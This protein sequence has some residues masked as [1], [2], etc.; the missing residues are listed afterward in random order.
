MEE[1]PTSFFFKTGNKLHIKVLIA[2]KCKSPCLLQPD[3]VFSESVG[4]PAMY[5]AF[6]LSP[7]NSHTPP[8]VH[9]HTHPNGNHFSAGYSE[10]Q[11]SHA[12]FVASLSKLQIEQGGC[13]ASVFCLSS[14]IEILEFWEIC[15]KRLLKELGKSWKGLANVG[16]TP[17]WR[18]QRQK[19]FFDLLLLSCLLVSFSTKAARYRN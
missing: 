10:Q 5:I 9:P 16:E 11:P 4:H 1:P 3:T 12:C 17:Q 13:R 18:A 14:D 8:H 2:Q 6:S 15:E 19:F 7:Y